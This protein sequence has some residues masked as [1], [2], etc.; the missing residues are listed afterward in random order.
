MYAVDN[1]QMALTVVPQSLS[2]WEH[3]FPTAGTASRAGT[4]QSTEDGS[5]A[6]PKV[7]GIQ[8]YDRELHEDE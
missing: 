6:Q 3:I 8:P 2:C 7:T 4:S 1:P 5:L